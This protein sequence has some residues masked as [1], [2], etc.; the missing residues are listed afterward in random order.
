V[1]KSPYEEK[2][3]VTGGGCIA[4]QGTGVTEAGA[5]LLLPLIGLLRRREDQA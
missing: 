4:P 2:C 3:S 1:T 5:W